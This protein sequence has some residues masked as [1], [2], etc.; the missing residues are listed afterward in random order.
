MP[1]KQT[2]RAANRQPRSARRGSALFLVLVL[3]MALG[4]LAT[5][6]VYLASNNTIITKLYDRE[7]DFRYGAEWALARGKARLTKDTTLILP[8]SLYLTLLSNSTVTMANGQAVPRVRVDLYA[9]LS[10]AVNG[11]YGRAVSL[12]AVASDASGARHVRRLE[13]AAENFA[14]Y[15]VFTDT[16]TAGLCYTTGEI[17]RGR[18]HSN[19]NWVSCGP[20]GPIYTDSVSA[21]TTLTGSAQ[22]QVVA[23]PGAQVIKFPTVS[24]LA[25]LPTL[26]SAAN[27][28]ITPVA[29]NQGGTRI[30]FLKWDL[31]GNGSDND[32]NEG[33]FMVFDGDVADDTSRTRAGFVGGNTR[34]D[35]Q[36]NHPAIKNDC[37]LWY[38]IGPAGAQRFVPV[39]AHNTNWF[40]AA[41]DNVP[42]ISSA[43]ASARRNAADSTIMKQAGARCYPAGDPRLYAS[44]V[45]GAAAGGDS[46]TFTAVTNSGRWRVF[47]GG[48]PAAVTASA[49]IPAAMKAY[50][51][52]IH[53]SLNPNSQGVIYVNGSVWVSGT[54]RGRVTLYASQDVKFIDDLVYATNPASLPI[55]QNLLGIIAGFDVWLSDNAINRP[56]RVANTTTSFLDDDQDFF[57]H[58]V[59]LSGVNKTDG[60]FRTEGY[61]TGPNANRTCTAVAGS[62]AQTS[63]GCINQAGGVIEKTVQPTFAGGWTGFAENRVKDAC[64]D[65]DSP[66]YFPLT[67]RYFD[68]EFYELDPAQFNVA[69]LYR[70]LQGAT[71]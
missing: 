26:A 14:R 64:L 61:N 20:P 44:E 58:A 40:E 37:G 50:L 12:V 7:R 45:A 29:W 48:T 70:T 42:G 68:N 54:L 22:Y 63:G 21:V 35:Q 39:I 67:G 41:Y 52:P 69:N 24:K 33:F 6:A 43:A 18:A 65:V 1:S 19:Q 38:P 47:P 46:T 62:T 60:S 4:G 36:P 23:A 55:C 16:W 9:G 66:P 17:V 25:L 71:P 27:L 11:Q 31:D 59:T 10:G 34:V 28:Y 57:L 56:R 3:T 15:A 13:L 32:A 51:W 8:D 2:S 49:T 53:R 30:Q 5:S